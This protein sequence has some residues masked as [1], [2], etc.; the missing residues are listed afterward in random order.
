MYAVPSYRYT[1]KTNVPGAKCAGK[2]VGH[3][4]LVSFELARKDLSRVKH[5]EVGVLKAILAYC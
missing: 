3:F 5:S 2:I 1:K 4:S